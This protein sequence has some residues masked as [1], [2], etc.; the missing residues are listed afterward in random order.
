MHESNSF[1]TLT[2]APEHLPDD[3][4]ISIR[5]LQ[6]FF[7]RLRKELDVP[8][9]YFA[10]GEYGEERGRPHYHAIIFGYDFSDDRTLWSKTDRGDLV[11]RSKTLEKCW[12]FG[13]SSIG[14]VSF[15]SCAYVARYV[16]KK[17]KGADDYVDPETGK[18]NAE[19]YKL[20]DPETGEVI[21]LQPEFCVMS[22]RPGIGRSWIEKYKN[23]T[24]KDF[25]TLDGNKF[26]LP[27]YYDQFLANIDEEKMKQ[28][29]VERMKKVDKE[30]NT[31]E[32]LAVK[33]QILERKLTQLSRNLGTK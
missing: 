23:D 15:E 21:D 6:L 27:K 30:D 29:K 24:D 16:M 12:T 2:Y 8:V 7:K 18:T 20:I 9:R 17:R 19:H 28:R 10:C 33:E 11:Y 14:S 3:H 26:P 25:V 4:S 13:H 22:R 32:R 5:E 31:R 1:I